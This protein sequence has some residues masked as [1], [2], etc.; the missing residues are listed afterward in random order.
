[1]SP[2]R[3]RVSNSWPPGFC[4]SSLTLPP[5]HGRVEQQNAPIAAPPT[6]PHIF[7]HGQFL[8][9]A[10][11]ANGRTHRGEVDSLALEGV[12]RETYRVH[13]EIYG[14]LDPLQNYALEVV[15]GC[16]DAMAQ[17][18][19]L[20]HPH[21]CARQEEPRRELSVWRGPCCWW[22]S[23]GSRQGQHALV[24]VVTNATKLSN[25]SRQRMHKL[26]PPQIHVVEPHVAAVSSLHQIEPQQKEVRRLGERRRLGACM[27]V[28]SR[29]VK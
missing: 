1:M 19:Q 13:I 18:P 25:N 8:S 20:H 10:W 27:R 26:A 3:A 17:P 21:R 29:G 12:S 4:L 7:S 15:P 2:S 23:R 28:E 24:D 16:K 6:K 14:T 11:H 5:D 9:A 22:L